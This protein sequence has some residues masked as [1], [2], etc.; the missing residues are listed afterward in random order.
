MDL[1]QQ[2]L[3]AARVLRPYMSRGQMIV[4]TT[5]SHGGEGIFALEL[6]VKMASNVEAMPSV[7]VNGQDGANAEAHLHY[8]YGGSDWYILEKNWDGGV[9]RAYGFV[10]LNGDMQNAEY[11]YV[12]IGDLVARGANLDLYFKTQTIA[13]VLARCH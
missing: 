11:G 2:A 3:V 4:L 5:A 8:F 1:K 9:D 6:F 12:D 10:V 13:E 7:L